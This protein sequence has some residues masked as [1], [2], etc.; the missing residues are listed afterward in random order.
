MPKAHTHAR[1]GHENTRDGD[2]GDGHTGD[3]DRFAKFFAVLIGDVD[4]GAQLAAAHAWDVNTV[5]HGHCGVRDQTTHN[6][7]ETLQK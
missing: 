6:W 3:T 2:L 4:A 7:R 1:G 5:G